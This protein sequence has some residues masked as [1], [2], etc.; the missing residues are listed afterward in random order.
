M[1]VFSESPV[2]QDP[3]W[4]G[5]GIGF[6]PRKMGWHVQLKQ[7]LFPTKECQLTTASSQLG[8]FPGHLPETCGVH[9]CLAV[10]YHDY[11]VQ[12]VATTYHIGCHNWRH[13][14]DLNGPFLALRLP[15][16]LTLH[17][18]HLVLTRNL[19]TPM[20]C[21]QNILLSWN[22]PRDKDGSHL[23]ERSHPW[24]C[25]GKCQL[26]FP[27]KTWSEWNES[28]VEAWHKKVKRTLS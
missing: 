23:G 11:P 13:H 9:H 17:H 14:P 15:F 2:L 24:L 10:F 26:I 21:Q 6:G 19:W 12:A 5:A 16:L 27:N 3:L 4:Q 20:P 28:K 7:P 1:E 22:K 8:G 25:A 18:W